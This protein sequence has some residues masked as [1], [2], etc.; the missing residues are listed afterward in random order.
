MDGTYTAAVVP[1]LSPQLPCRVMCRVGF[2]DCWDSEARHC[3][4]VMTFG[5]EYVI[6]PGTELSEIEF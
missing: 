1:S 4:I 3:P 6:E 2:D 5:T